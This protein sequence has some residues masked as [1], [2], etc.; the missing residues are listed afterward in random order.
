MK[1][2]TTSYKINYSEPLNFNNLDA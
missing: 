2:I 1:K